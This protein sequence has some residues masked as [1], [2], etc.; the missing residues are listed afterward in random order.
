MLSPL[1]ISNSLEIK[2]FPCHWQLRRGTLHLTET[3]LSQA[4]RGITEDDWRRKS[5]RGE[6]PYGGRWRSLW[7]AFLGLAAG[8]VG[9][10]SGPTLY[11]VKGKVSVGGAPLTSGIVMFAPDTGRGNKESVGPIGTIEPDGSYKLTTN[12]KAGAPAGWYKVTVSTNAPPKEGASSA[13]PESPVYVNPVYSDPKATPLS[14]EVI[15]SPQEGRYD[16]KLVQ[17]QQ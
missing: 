9:C 3:P 15:D 12:G 2:V 14:F 7:V 1:H 13:P 8:I 6:I 17:S 4:P 11:P 5:M 16:L 10:D